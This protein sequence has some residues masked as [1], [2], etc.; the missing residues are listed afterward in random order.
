MSGTTCANKADGHARDPRDAGA[1]P[2]GQHVDPVGIDA[3]RRGHAGFCVTARTSSP[4]RVRFRI[5][6][7]HDEEDQRRGR[8][9]RC[10]SS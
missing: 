3:H 9:S 2:E 6:P 8:R 1:E 5:K 4:S 7:Q 10:G